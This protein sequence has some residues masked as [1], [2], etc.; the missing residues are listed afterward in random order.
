MRQREELLRK[1]SSCQ[2]LRGCFGVHPWETSLQANA[3]CFIPLV[4]V[5]AGAQCIGAGPAPALRRAPLRLSA[6]A[7]KKVVAIDASMR[8]WFHDVHDVQ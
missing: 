8:T 5:K 1:K 7:S 3:G 2:T 6:E 4:I